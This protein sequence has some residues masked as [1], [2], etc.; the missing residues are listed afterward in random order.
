[1]NIIRSGVNSAGRPPNEK[2]RWEDRSVHFR[3]DARNGGGLPKTGEMRTK[4]EGLFRS[5]CANNFLSVLQRGRNSA[6]R[7]RDA[8]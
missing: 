4:N 6:Q 3:K 5:F 1:M 7:C 8:A 2:T